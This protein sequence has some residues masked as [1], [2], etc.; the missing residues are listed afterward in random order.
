MQP[1]HAT[2]RDASVRKYDLLTSLA[3]L[4]LSEG[5]NSG[6]SMLR[7]ISAITARYNWARDELAIGQ[8]DLAKMWSVNVRTVKRE[9]KRLREAEFLVL[10]KAG[11]KGRV[12]V[13]RLNQVKI[14]EMTSGLWELVGPDLADRMREQIKAETIRE[15]AKIVKFPNVTTN[16]PWGRAQRELAARDPARFNSWFAKLEL[17]ESTLNEITLKAP[18]DFQ[19]RYVAD[20]LVGEIY[21]ALAKTGGPTSKVHITS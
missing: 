21:E 7:L 9:I 18:S 20:R 1:K 14:E 11:A 4:G 15:E 19:A 12:S 13:Y 8:D 16:C 5:K 6:I 2:G 3:V 17:I 10:K